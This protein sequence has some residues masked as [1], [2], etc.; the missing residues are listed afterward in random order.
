MFAPITLLLI[1]SSSHCLRRSIINIF[2]Y[3]CGNVG[4]KTAD[5]KNILDSRLKT[6]LENVRL[7]YLL[8]REEAGWDA[9][10]NWQDIL[11]LGEQQRLGMVS[12]INTSHLFKKML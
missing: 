6:I 7:N 8:E 2:L 9:N 10:V 1:H 3:N 4:Q 5:T 11:S 12:Q